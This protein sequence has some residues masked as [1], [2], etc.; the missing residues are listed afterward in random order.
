LV[1]YFSGLILAVEK[2]CKRQ[3]TGPLEFSLEEQ[4]NIISVSEMVSLHLA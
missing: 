3:L 4:Q 1:I 2:M